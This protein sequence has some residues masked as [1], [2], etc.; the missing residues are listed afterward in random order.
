MWLNDGVQV[1]PH[2]ASSADSLFFVC[3]YVGTEGLWGA[4]ITLITELDNEGQD[5]GQSPN[6]SILLRIVCYP[7]GGPNKVLLLNVSEQFLWTFPATPCFIWL[8]WNNVS[9][10]IVMNPR[11]VST[12]Q[13]NKLLKRRTSLY[14]LMSWQ[15]L[16]KLFGLHLNKMQI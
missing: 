12:E 8:S 9:N 7:P 1:F 11:L 13:S 5:L 10:W 6:V 15:A 14:N 3:P 4:Y 2:P 16:L